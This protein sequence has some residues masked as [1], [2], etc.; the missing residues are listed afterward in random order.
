MGM[1]ALITAI[2]KQSNIAASCPTSAAA[3]VKEE[4]E[5]AGAP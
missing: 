2:V 5:A 4:I 3:P 1:T